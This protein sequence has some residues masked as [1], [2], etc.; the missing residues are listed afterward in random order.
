MSALK[1]PGNVEQIA[2]NATAQSDQVTDHAEWKLEP[3]PSSAKVLRTEIHVEAGKQV[4]CGITQ[5]NGS[6]DISGDISALFTRTLECIATAVRDLSD[7]LLHAEKVGS[8]VSAIHLHHSSESATLSWNLHIPEAICSG[9]QHKEFIDCIKYF[10]ELSCDQNAWDDAALE[11]HPQSS[12]MSNVVTAAKKLRSK[13]GDAD[14]LPDTEVSCTTWCESIAFG[15]K[16]GPA[17]DDDEETEDREWRGA[18][19][20]FHLDKREAYFLKDC[21]MNGKTKTILVD[22]EHLVKVQKLSSFELTTCTVNLVEHSKGGVVEHYE[23]KK[24]SGEMDNIF[25]AGSST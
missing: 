22:P 24:I 13:I 5:G 21:K 11:N 16:I 14:L 17:P 19:R 18:F 6:L 1:A 25:G 15:K 23:L 20:G 7:E 8:L 10:A 12:P 2:N 9:V 3:S 4:R